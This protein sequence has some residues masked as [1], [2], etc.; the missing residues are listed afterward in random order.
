[1]ENIKKN[2]SE[3][4]DEHVEWIERLAICKDEVKSFIKSLEDVIA[5]DPD[6]ETLAN[7]EHF[8]NQFIRH[9]EVIDEL[10]HDVKGEEK[11]II[12]ESKTKDITTDNRLFDENMSLLDQ[13]KSFDKIFRELKE[14]YQSF[15][16]K[17]L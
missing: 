3:L 17:V 13:M 6:N 15:L 10:R 11:K 12:R 14:E 8:Q 1:M 2:L 16:Q 5:S 9:I 4:H 7:V